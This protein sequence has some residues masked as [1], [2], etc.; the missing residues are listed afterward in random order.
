MLVNAL[1]MES[2]A[3]GLSALICAIKPFT[4]SRELICS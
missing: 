1:Y 4:F 3:S 2:K